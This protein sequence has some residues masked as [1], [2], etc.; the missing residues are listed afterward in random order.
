MS[1]AFCKA[2]MA[3][4]MASGT[5][6]HLPMPD[7]T[8]C[9]RADEPLED[10]PPIGREVCL[11]PLRGTGPGTCLTYPQCPCGSRD[12]VPQAGPCLQW[13][14]FDSL[15]PDQQV[16]GAVVAGGMVFCE[17]SKNPYAPEFEAKVVNGWARGIASALED[18]AN[19]RATLPSREAAREFCAREARRMMQKALDDL[20]GR[21]SR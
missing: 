8:R 15:F 9:P 11:A 3:Q 13:R 2:T 1:C 12:G 21:V 17:T 19:A 18:P 4:A 6:R 20:D 7:G 14:R 5:F 10:A 16:E